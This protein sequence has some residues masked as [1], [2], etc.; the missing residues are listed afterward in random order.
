MFSSVLQTGKLRK[1]DESSGN[2]SGMWQNVFFNFNTCVALDRSLAKLECNIINHE[3]GTFV[4]RALHENSDKCD[5]CFY[6]R[7]LCCGCF[8]FTGRCAWKYEN[9]A[10]DTFAFC[11]SPCRCHLQHNQKIL[12]THLNFVNFT[13]KYPPNIL[14]GLYAICH[15]RPVWTH[16]TTAFTINIIENSQSTLRA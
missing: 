16:N 10:L 3:G 4:C 14:K 5:M 11:W 1:F 15:K 7:P 13:K 2:I 8:G 6:V 12:E 9:T